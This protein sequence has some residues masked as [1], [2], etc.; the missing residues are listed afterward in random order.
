M[1]NNKK[2]VFSILVM[3]IMIIIMIGNIAF[4]SSI[5]PQSDGRVYINFSSPYASYDDET[6]KDFYCI[7]KGANINNAYYNVSDWHDVEDPMLAYILSLDINKSRGYDAHNSKNNEIQH[8]LWY[9]IDHKN[10]NDTTAMKYNNCNITGGGIGLSST[11]LY[12]ING[13]KYSENQ[14]WGMASEYANR[15]N[16]EDINLNLSINGTN[17]RATWTGN[18]EN[19][20]VYLNGSDTAYK[21]NITDKSIDIPITEFGTNAVAKVKIVAQQES[22][23]AK[24]KVYVSGASQNILQKEGSRSTVSKQDEKTIDLNTNVSLQKYITKVNNNNLTSEETALTDRKNTYTSADESNDLA[25]KVVSKSEQNNMKSANTYKKEKIV[26]IEAGDTVTYR[27]YVYNNSSVVNAKSVVIK[28]TIPF[29]E[30]NGEVKSLASIENIKDASGNEVTWTKDTN[31]SN[32]NSYEYTI[33]NLAAGQST[34]FDVTLK[35]NDYNSGIITNTAWISST[36]PKNDETYRT[37]DRDYV[38]MK[39]YKI[40]LEKFVSQVTDKD[41]NNSVT[42]DS[43]RQGKRYNDEARTDENKNTY[44]PSHKVQVEPGDIVTY[45][46]RLKNTGETG[47]KIHQIYDKFDVN[48]NGVKLK[49]YESYG[50][51][52]NGG[53]TIENNDYRGPNENPDNSWKENNYTSYLIKFDKPTLIQPGKTVDITIKFNVEVPTELTKYIQELKNIA[54]I[55]G[56]KNK[57]DVELPLPSA[58]GDGIDN[59]R[60]ADYVQTKI[61][62]VSL[63]KFVYKVNGYELCDFDNDGSVN[64]TDSDLLRKYVTDFS[65]IEGNIKDKITKYGDLDGNGKIDIEDYARFTHYIAGMS[66]SNIKREGY[67][68]H[69]YDDDTNTNNLW[70]YNHVVTVSKGDNVTYKI[71]LM[72]D[73]ETDVYITKV[74]DFFPNGVTFGNRTFNGNEYDVTK[75][76]D[77]N[78]IEFEGN[79]IT[80]GT[81][82]EHGKSK[83]FEVTVKVNESNMS[84]NILKNT[85]TITEMKNRNNVNVIDTTPNNNTD[86]DYLQLNYHLNDVPISGMVWNDKNQ[87]KDNNKSGYNALYQG[88]GET[89]NKLSGIVVKL[90]RK[91]VDFAIATKTTDS[92]GYYYFEDKDID[93]AVVKNAYERHI[94]GPMVSNDITR[95][96]GK[97]Y[98]YYIEFEYDGITYTTTPDGKSCVSVTDS[99]A[100]SNGKYKINS[101][102]KEDFKNRKDFND[103]FNTINNNSLNSNEKIDYTTK[104]EHGYIPQSVYNYKAF[105]TMKSST[106]TIQLSDNPVL[107]EE[108]K[109]INLGLRGRDLFDLE[110]TSDVEKIDVNVNGIN[111]TYEFANIV[112][113][114][115]HDLGS[116]NNI[117]EDMANIVS[118]KQDKYVDEYNNDGQKIRNTDKP[119]LN[120]IY[121]TYKITV[122]NTSKT[123]GTATKIINYYD[124]IYKFERAYS[125]NNNLNVTNFNY[126]DKCKSIIIDTPQTYLSENK[127]MDIYVVY[128]LEDISRIKSLKD[129]EKLETYNMAEIYEYKTIAKDNNNEFVRGLIDKD[130]APGSVSTEKVCL[131]EGNSNLSTLDYYLNKQ[132]TDKIKYEDD[133]FVTPTLYF[134][135]D[136]NERV[137]TGYVFEDSTTVNSKTKVKS[138]NG[139]KDAGEKGIKG[140]NVIL[141]VPTSMN[142]KG[143]VEYKATTGNKG[144]FTISGFIP[145]KNADLTYWYGD[146]DATFCKVTNGKSYNGEDFESANNDGISKKENYWYIIN[147]NRKGGPKSVA[148]DVESDGNTEVGT[149]KGVSTRVSKYDYSKLEILNK[150][151]AGNITETSKDSAERKVREDTKMHSKTQTFV[152]NVEKADENGARTTNGIE[153]YEISN[154]NFGIQEVPVTTI[155]L[156]TAVK[157]FVIT[158]ASGDNT[159]ASAKRK[160]VQENG[161][162]VEKWDVIGN[163]LAPGYDQNETTTV[164]TKEM[165]KMLDVSIEEEKI[166]GAKLIIRYEVT[167]DQKIERDFKGTGEIKAVIKGLVDYVDNDLSFNSDTIIEN[168]T[169]NSDYWETTT[170][171]ATQDA[172][173]AAIQ[174]RGGTVEND[175][176][177]GSVDIEEIDNDTIV[178]EAK[179]YT[180]IL[181][182]KNNVGLLNEK[183]YKPGKDIYGNDIETASCDLVLQ[184]V[185]SAHDNTLSNIVESTVEKN[186]Y[187]NKVEITGLNYENTQDGEIVN[188]DRVRTPKLEESNPDYITESW[189]T[190]NPGAAIGYNLAESSTLSEHPPTGD[191]IEHNNTVYYIIATASLTVLAVGVVLIKKFAIKKD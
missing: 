60:D 145:G 43:E 40:S 51:Q 37:V 64:V 15:V 24:F 28:D 187:E 144:L 148:T 50:I 38:K 97:Y 115:R 98:A 99:E 165:T 100:Y 122:Q 171:D 108:I 119:Y 86:S 133:T 48:S 77:E 152:L 2:I 190:I 59:N 90:Y 73:G 13:T 75:I 93:K 85:A 55:T 103:K 134:I 123:N 158:D 71:K 82:L 131:S 16:L 188:A 53:G 142:S 52:G 89:E 8:L 107:E 173:K 104:N 127:T 126:G 96:A 172:F 25:K 179:K 181:K 22:C 153:G 87:A 149:R 95:W 146:S 63:E 27:I 183:N 184:K 114:R 182:L 128:K 36:D 65:S 17:V 76:V 118:E 1:S 169:K 9:Y 21:S 34:Y 105:M 101:N 102:A 33:T 163:V 81:I 66:N 84:L 125:G 6:F 170:Y 39:E 11:A 150:V 164:D 135:S 159:I 46:I 174:A 58:D 4:S 162:W 147:S 57:N 129:K 88:N 117:T 3:F 69:N 20:S 168:N 42:Y 5:T 167:A 109:Y 83:A 35:Y 49:Y 141:H 139:V 130:S 61:Y 140:V 10:N 91:G 113:V 68:E 154:M 161:K 177:Y 151:R 62:A 111:Q 137:L 110:L 175:K 80:A 44:K 176:I 116:N 70:K 166:Q 132:G 120:Y 18:A 191:S 143:Y 30:N 94:K 41:G 54:C 45:T 31:T 78:G 56:F 67:A 23:S 121:V 138:G 155:D 186:E 72:N 157:E 92:E 136:G 14:L 112:T 189:M 106:E 156:R 124:N 47:V 160:Y 185:L 79:D 19:Y 178:P 7:Q 74:K 29:V 12:T 180:T 26:N 32:K